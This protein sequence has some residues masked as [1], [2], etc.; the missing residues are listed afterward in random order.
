M[1]TFLSLLLSIFSLIFFI[2][3]F[4][5]FTLS[6]KIEFIRKEIPQ[7]F[8]LEKSEA[9]LILG[10]MGYGYYGGENTDAIFVV[11]LKNNRGYII[12]IPRD[13][14]VM[15][16]NNE[17]YKINTL[18]S[19]KKIDKILFEVSSLTGIKITKYFVFDN[20]LLKKV[21]D[22]L[23]GLD[24]DLKYPVSDALS[25]Y[26]LPPG[27]KKLSGEWV[28]FVVRSRHYPQGDFTRMK[29]QFI[30]IN[31]LKEKINSISLNEFLRLSNLI[32]Q[33]KNHFETNLDYS[34]IFKLVSK[35]KKIILK[36]IIIDLNSGLWRDDYFQVK[37]NNHSDYFYVYGLI[38]KDGIGK[39]E[40]I[41][42]KIKEEITK[43]Y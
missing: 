6:K 30:I 29:N 5:T 20:Y 37:L 10:K 12:H 35:F 41:R 31:S 26:T 33:S 23:G 28:E 11:Y 9:V 27:R 39:Y 43:G 4:E 13:L 8:K 40:N 3:L 14:I 17:T 15:V 32:F 21:V 24:V 18:Y 2:Y 42:K 16:D 25:G 1:K 7:L 36:D 38:P 34:E 19:L 22:A